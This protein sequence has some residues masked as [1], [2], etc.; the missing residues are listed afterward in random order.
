M[1]LYLGNDKVTRVTVAFDG[2]GTTSGTDTSD[3]T[4]TSGAQMLSG[5]TAYSKGTKYTGTI[6]TVSAPTPTISVSDS[7]L[8]TASV[9]NPKGYQSSATTKTVTQ[10]LTTKAATTITPSSASQT[11]VDSGVYTTGKITV[12]AVPTEIKTI[13]ANGTYSPSSGKYFSSVE[14][15]VAGDVPTYQ[16]KTVSPSTSAQTVTADDGYDALSD[17]TVNAI[18]TETK[19]VTPTTSAQTITPTSGKY[20][21]QVDVEAIQT[22]TKSVT[23]NGTYNPTSGKYFSSVTVNVPAETF[24]TQTKTVTPTESTQTVSPDNGYD[25]LSTVTV[26]PI[27][28]TYVGSAVPTKGATTITPNSNSQTAISFGT[29]A[30][31]DVIVSAV[32]TE[33]K[34][35]TANGTYTPSDGKYFSSVSVSVVGDTFDTQEKSVT[36]TESEQVVG[37]DAG[38]DGLSSV[39]V[40]AISSTYIGSGI[41]HKSAETYTP[42][43]NA[44]IISAGQYLDGDQTIAAISSTY[45]GSGVTRKEAAT[46]IPSESEQTI[47]ANQYLTGVQT[48]SAIPSD[49]VGSDVT[50]KSA[51]IITPT[52]SEQVIS[53]GQYL[54]GAQTISAIPSTYVGSGVPTQGAKTVTPSTSSQ[55]VVSSGTYVTGNIEVSAMPTGALSNPTINTSTGVVTVGVATSGYLDT[56]ATK[57]LQL[58]TKE[59]TTIT[60]STSSQ[61][62]VSTG[63]YVTGDILVAEIP[64]NYVDTSD[65]NATA[66]DIVI[67]KNAYVN[68][69]KVEGTLQNSLGV[70]VGEPSY[71]YQAVTLPL[72]TPRIAISIPVVNDCVIRST[73]NNKVY[74]NASN[75]GDATTVDVISGKTFT[76]E[77]GLKITGTMPSKDAATYT[78]TTTDQTIDAGQYL[79]GTQTIQGDANL[80]PEN[81]ASGVSIFG[82]TGTHQGG[83]GIDTSDATATDADIVSG[84]T[85]YVNGAKVTGTLVVQNYYT[86]TTTPE[87][88]TGEDG[89]LYF[90]VVR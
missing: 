23:S 6:A 44:Q 32:P 39:T 16:S 33:T 29:Y 3:A 11:A 58:T 12:S 22:E 80:V 49:Y 17:V 78:P 28:S 1:P 82:V 10:Q 64:E 41:A 90:K 63:T 89:D 21:T 42:T 83:S 62:A 71:G 34:S 46:I 48:I 85:A 8:I 57:T 86:G 9:S 51:A 25:G 54:D 73:G 13:T 68:G 7:G 4:L 30:T 27:S 53:A 20:L 26:N 50:R 35:I 59:A 84:K 52:E 55:T 31:G 40:G 56:S 18:Q 19:S 67:S 76:S 75:F 65:A 79:S 15:A 37:P 2:S 69:I 14:V 88:T 47:A 72:G 43:E 24:N 87:S 81:I 74:T 38:Y 70:N 60:P 66:S 61:T 36:P 77:S 45:V 5:V